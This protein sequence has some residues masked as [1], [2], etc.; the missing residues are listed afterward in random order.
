MLFF[1]H[2]FNLVVA[3]SCNCEGFVEQLRARLQLV[4][5]NFTQ[6]A[7]RLRRDKDEIAKERDN[8]HLQAINLRRQKFTHEKEAEICRH[9]CKMD[10]ADSL[11]GISNVT[12]AFL[13]KVDS[14]FPMHMAFQLTCSKQ[15]DHLEQIRSN[16]TSLSREV[17]DKF[18]RYLNNVGEQ[19]SAIQEEN[20]RLKAENW[21]LSMD[22]RSCSQN[23]TAIILQNKQNL[24]NLQQKHDEKM[25]RELLSKAILKG[26][27]VVLNNS[28]N[29]K[30]KEVEYLKEQLK[31]LDMSCKSKVSVYGAAKP[32]AF[33]LLLSVSVSEQRVCLLRPSTGRYVRSS[34]F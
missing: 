20:I 26:D 32:L 4:E 3:G 5:S 9:Q 17:E 6:V 2:F 16:C 28:V 30:N 8:L 10:F 33:A 27:I 12:R 21:R 18:Q 14:L 19:V 24:D 1:L 23:R 13:A 22:Y 11:S 7:Q 15:S 34:L 25:E 31:H 29:V